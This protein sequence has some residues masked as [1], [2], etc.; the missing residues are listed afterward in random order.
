MAYMGVKKFMINYLT[1]SS[2]FIDKSYLS[3][4][5][6]LLLF[7][8]NS[9]NN[10][11]MHCWSKDLTLCNKV[12]LQWYR[13][14]FK[15]LNTH[16]ISEIKLSG[17]ETTLYPKL[18]E[19]INI[20]REYVPEEIQLSIFS[21]GNNL[22][23]SNI[24]DIIFYLKKQVG[25]NTNICYQ[26]SADEYHIASYSRIHKISFN[27]ACL[28]Y[29]TFLKNFI[30]AIKHIKSNYNIDFNGK[31]KVH[32]N[33]GRASYHRGVLYKNINEN[34]WENYF[35]VTEGLV[36][37]GNANYIKESTEIQ[38]SNMWTA[39]IMPGIVISDNLT[40]DSVPFK[41]KE[42]LVYLNLSDQIFSGTVIMGWWNLINRIFVGGSVI[43]F[44]NYVK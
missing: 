10:N 8:T 40:K 36:K 24:D 21:N 28:I 27:S 39:F 4:K 43:D 15:R 19:L 23:N 2:N 33:F 7:I 22:L 14:F 13:E 30:F 16:L 17:G 20:I 31:I 11:C 32:C 3:N 42:S 38:E 26:I 18:P 12:N 29:E 35:L 34:D 44:I 25:N 41:Y 5:F 9:C 6:E 37:S 1:G